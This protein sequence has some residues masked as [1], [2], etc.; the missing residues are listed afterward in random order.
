MDSYDKV[1]DKRVR[2]ISNVDLTSIFK[3]AF[4]S[5]PQNSTLG[6][7]ATNGVDVY[8]FEVMDEGRYTYCGRIELVDKPYTETQPGED[9][10]DRL[11]WMF[12]IRPVPENDVKKPSMFVFKDMEDYQKNGQNVDAKYNAGHKVKVSKKSP[13]KSVQKVRHKKFGEGTVVERKGEFI[14]VNF[15]SVGR[16]QLNLKVCQDK[17]LME[18]V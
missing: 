3:C 5:K 15:A 16:K 8:L 2:E 9:G 14:V 6:N 13:G 4:I 1:T 10:I 18:F 7:C 11:V 17:G 12:P